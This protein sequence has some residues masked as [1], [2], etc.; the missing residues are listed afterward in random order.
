MFFKDLIKEKTSG[1]LCNYKKIYYLSLIL[2]YYHVSLFL[3]TSELWQ[4]LTMKL[5]YQPFKCYTAVLLTLTDIFKT[6]RA[7]LLNL[8]KK[9]CILSEDGIKLWLLT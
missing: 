2:V 7:V 3:S 5:F 9:S 1:I 8:F 6:C 4:E